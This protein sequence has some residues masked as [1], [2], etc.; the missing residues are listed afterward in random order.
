MGVPLNHPCEWDFLYKPTILG[1][2]HLRKPPYIHN[3]FYYCELPNG[4]PFARK[5]QRQHLHSAMA[6]YTRRDT[7]GT[8]DLLR[9]ATPTRPHQ[10][11]NW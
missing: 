6:R 1:Y 10:S 11:L 8:T 4:T 9:R 3:K 5:C 2:P 7:T